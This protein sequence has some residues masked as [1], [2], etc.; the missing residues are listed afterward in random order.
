MIQDCRGR[1]GS[2]GEWGYIECEAPDGYDTVEWAAAQPW[3]NRRVGMFGASYMG[4][5]QWLAAVAAASASGGD[6]ARVLCR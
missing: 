4:Y 3:S 1:F 6:G 2:E 5:T